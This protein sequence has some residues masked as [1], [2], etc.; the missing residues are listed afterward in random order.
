MSGNG[1]DRR[2]QQDDRQDIHVHVNTNEDRPPGEPTP[3]ERASFATAQ[4]LWIVAV[5][6]VIVLIV[7]LFTSGLID[8]G[9]GDD[10]ALE[11]T[12]SP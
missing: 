4:L 8:F 6:L 12:V 7:V 2:D 5:V 3:E 11:A 1:N 10:G 9:G